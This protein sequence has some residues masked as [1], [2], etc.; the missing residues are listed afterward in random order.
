[1]VRFSPLNVRRLLVSMIR[2]F[3]VS[4]VSVEHF[5]LSLTKKYY[6][7]FNAN[8]KENILNLPDKASIKRPLLLF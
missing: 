3:Y 6:C 2:V 4:K 1:M 5:F 8:M 7:L